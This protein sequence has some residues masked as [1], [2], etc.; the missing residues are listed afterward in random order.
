[1][2][3]WISW[4]GIKSIRIVYNYTI[5]FLIFSIFCLILLWIVRRTLW[6][7]GSISIGLF[8]LIIAL[9]SIQST[10]KQLKYIQIDYW[11]TRGIDL[12]D[13]KKYHDALQAHI[14]AISLD[15]KSTKCWINKSNTLSKQGNKQ[16]EALDAIQSAVDLGPK[17]S[18]T[19]RKWTPD[20]WKAVQEYANAWNT[21]GLALLD[22]AN[23]IEKTTH[24]TYVP[25]D[26]RAQAIKAFN[27]SIELFKYQDDEFGQKFG[28]Y[29]QAHPLVAT[30]YSRFGNIPQYELNSEIIAPWIGKGTALCCL[31][32]Y[33]EAIEAC[34]NAIEVCIR[35][36]RHSGLT[37]PFLKHFLATTYFL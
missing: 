19:W 10:T 5:Y 22:L 20:E 2:C 3:K 27:K 7:F 32:K 6:E 8:A 26:L 12:R 18:A 4:N 11:N 31:G 30:I 21:K 33:N 14:K 15:P 24:I 9:Y 1:M 13:K 35:S 29:L 23:S 17:H 36:I 28:L 16:K 25:P 37:H 34:N